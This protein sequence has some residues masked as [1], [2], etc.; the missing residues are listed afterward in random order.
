MSLSMDYWR[1]MFIAMDLTLLLVIPLALF[2]DMCIK[3]KSKRRKLRQKI[4]SIISCF[5]CSVIFT[6]AYIIF[7][8]YVEIVSDAAH[9]TLYKRMGVIFESTNS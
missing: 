4:L 9:S 1:I 3:R 8:N 6:V 7:Y 2:K 5:L